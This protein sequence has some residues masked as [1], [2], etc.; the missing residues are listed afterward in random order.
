VEALRLAPPEDVVELII[1]VL[2]QFLDT[3]PTQAP[4]WLHAAVQELP[5]DILPL[6]DKVTYEEQFRRRDSKHVEKQLEN[7]A[8]RCKNAARRSI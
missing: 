4:S 5:D 1:D 8:T 7:L 3:F 6:E 2:V